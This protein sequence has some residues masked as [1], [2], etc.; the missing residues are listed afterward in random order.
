MQRV[1]GGDE[2][3]FVSHGADQ[4]MVECIHRTRRELNLVDQLRVQQFLDVHLDA[5]TFDQIR[6]ETRSNDRGR[7]E[8]LLGRRRESIDTRGDRRLQRRRYAD[9]PVL[10]MAVR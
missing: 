7:T 4:W 6:L 2:L 8:R 5:E 9:L 1:A 10:F 3:G